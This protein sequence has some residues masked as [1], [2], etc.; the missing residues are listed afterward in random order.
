MLT[1][2]I[3]GKDRDGF[4]IGR[5]YSI[6]AGETN[7]FIRNT[8][9]FNCSKNK[10]FQSYVTFFVPTEINLEKIYGQD[11]VLKKR[12][13]I[14]T[15]SYKTE[16]KTYTIDGEVKGNEIYFD[17]S[18][19]QK[20]AVASIIE[21]KAIYLLLSDDKY[22]IEYFTPDEDFRLPFGGKEYKF[23]EFVRTMVDRDGSFSR[24][25]NT[26]YFFRTCTDLSA[27]RQ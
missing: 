18:N 21:A 7:N 27:W 8:I 10:E 2:N 11:H 12:F 9:N 6:V 13:R 22:P 19:N 17:F 14:Y 24:Q 5:R 3:S 23:N 15:L 20:D 25:L 1:L 4:T 26:D 16:S